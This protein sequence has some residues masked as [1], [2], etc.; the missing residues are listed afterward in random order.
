M[1]LCH[2]CNPNKLDL[3]K[4]QIYIQ[5][6]DNGVVKAWE[7]KLHSIKVS[8]IPSD[9]IIQQEVK[10][11]NISNDS[12]DNLINRYHNYY[13]F[14]M[15]LS[16]NDNEMINKF[17]YDQN[18]YGRAIEDLSFNMV[19]YVDLTTNNNDTIPL[20]HSQ[21]TR[22]YGVTHN[23]SVQLVFKNTGI[24]NAKTININLNGHFLELNDH[25][26]VFNKQDMDNVPG[27]KFIVN[28]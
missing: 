5:D 28:E 3:E 16:Y 2:A 22:Y 1:L 14:N 27:L 15:E 13:Y 10:N 25:V 17:L 20:L 9:I 8:Y 4:L 24:K 26:F 18:R 21:F 12:L 11:K 19:R 23:N 6:E 7:D